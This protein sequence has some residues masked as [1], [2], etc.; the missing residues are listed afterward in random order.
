MSDEKDAR[1]E[2]VSFTTAEGTKITCSVEVARKLGYSA[3]KKST[4]KPSS[5]K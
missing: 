3:P 2:V 5:T 4:A 1:P